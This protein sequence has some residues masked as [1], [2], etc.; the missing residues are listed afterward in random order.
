MK[1]LSTL[2]AV[3]LSLS[4]A[5]QF[6]NIKLADQQEGQ[7]PPSEPSI[8]INK[9][10]PKNIVA[11]AILDRVMY[12][13]DGGETWKETRLSSPYG[14]NGDPSLISD[15]KGH[16]YYFHL[17][18][19]NRGEDEWLDRIVCQKSTD[20]GKTWSEGES[21]GFNPPKDQDKEWVA[22]HPKKQVICTTWTQFDKYGEKDPNCHSNIMF[23][24][25]ENGGKK[26]S[27]AIQLNQN[28]GDCIDDDNTAEGAVPVIDSEGRIFVAW[29]NG[30]HIYLDRSFDGGTMWLTN[31][32]V[33][34]EH[35]GGWDMNI[36]GINRANGMP[37]LMI[38]NS[39]SRFHGSLYLL[40]ADQKNGENDT[41]IWFTRSTSRGDIWT[42]P[43]RINK[44]GP[45]KHQFFPWMAVDQTTGN[46]YIVYYDRRA[47]NDWQTDV[48]MAYSEDGGNSF[49]EIKISETPFTPEPG[50]FFG[51]Y[52]NISAH[53]GII[54]PIWTRMDNGK[55]SVWTA[56]IKSEELIK[57]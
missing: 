4:A 26:W 51:D 32:L 41:D 25:S 23:S 21:I 36:P 5:A 24:I 44:D 16:L 55:T 8:S 3:A 38:D 50:K 10:N 27:K 19:P 1:Y 31:D 18:H 6:K 13:L 9:K 28:P 48:Y 30:G 56:I 52:T 57:K 22:V 47:Y 37:V 42:P 43:V 17:S 29:S 11:G 54:A 46:I 2:L 12:T 53:K 45:G 20:G 14:V 33:V 49:K 39:P 7:Y 35:P 34:A 40:W 15:A